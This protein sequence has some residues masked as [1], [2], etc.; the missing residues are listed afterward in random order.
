M[1]IHIHSL[2]IIKAYHKLGSYV[3]N[4]KCWCTV[5]FIVFNKCSML[6]VNVYHSSQCIYYT[7]NLL[8]S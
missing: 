1:K 4:Y 3:Y 6:S 2:I 8:T 7:T 5:T